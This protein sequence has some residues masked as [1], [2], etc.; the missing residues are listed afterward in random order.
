MA[1]P[2]EVLVDGGPERRA[3]ALVESA[4]AEAWRVERAYSRYRDDNVTHRIHASEGRPADVDRETARLLDFA[5]HCHAVSGGAFDITSGAL[6]R[7]WGSGAALR[8]PDED[9]V[10]ALLAL[11]G[12]QQ[13][14]WKSP[15]LTLPAGMEIDFG[16][17]GKEY[18]V[19]RVVTVLS[20]RSERALLVNFGGDLRANAPPAS[21]AW[22]IAVESVA[23][24]DL[25]PALTV[26]DGT[27]ELRRG[28]MATSGD[29]RRHVVRDGVRFGHVLDPR[30]GWPVPDAPRSVTVLGDSCTQAGLLA[31]LALLH[32]VHAETF[33]EGEGVPF[34]CQRDESR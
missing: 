32:G 23:V 16:G 18:A 21:G 24:T 1:S 8:V 30:T 9:E 4:A 17:I 6:R 31:T 19:D 28:A 2:C 12:W 29:A 33:L 27:L 15:R 25:D 5:A 14:S 11:V 13:V 3:R 26:P 22:R 7:A 20:A 34:R 10:G